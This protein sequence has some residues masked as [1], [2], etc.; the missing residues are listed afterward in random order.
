MPYTYVYDAA[1]R[2]I[3]HNG[4]YGWV[5]V[6][7]INPGG[8]GQQP[9]YLVT[10]ANLNLRSGPSL[11]SPVLKIIPAGAQV[12]RGDQ[13]SNGY[14]AVTYAGVSGWASTAYLK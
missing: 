12:A 14:R 6:D 2:L 1:Y 10:T 13:V 5:H 9:G 7:F 11:D 8:S 3:R 4:Q